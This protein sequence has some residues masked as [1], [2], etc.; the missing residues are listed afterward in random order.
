M[1]LTEAGMHRVFSSKTSPEPDFLL[2][3]RAPVPRFLT[4]W[5]P[6]VGDPRP[7]ARWPQSRVTRKEAEGVGLMR[8]S[9]KNSFLFDSEIN[10]NGEI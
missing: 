5:R 2:L 4:S 10:F 8:V 6:D 1:E 7:Q 3:E 9:T